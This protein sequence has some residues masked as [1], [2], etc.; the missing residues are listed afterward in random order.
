MGHDTIMT[1]PEDCYEELES[2]PH[3]IEGRSPV[4]ETLTEAL[5]AEFKTVIESCEER[6]AWQ[7][8]QAASLAKLLANRPI[9]N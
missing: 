9:S 3:Q 2:T 5:V 6:C 8:A 7:E 4:R 1:M